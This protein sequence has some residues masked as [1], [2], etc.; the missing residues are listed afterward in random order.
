MSGVDPRE[1]MGEN[2]HRT[3][4]GLLGDS[5]ERALFNMFAW[6][7]EPEVSWTGLEPL[8]RAY[9]HEPLFLFLS[10]SAIAPIHAWQILPASKIPIPGGR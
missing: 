8:F 10:L 6:Y 4:N 7:L 5:E 2:A 3:S 9:T 1:L